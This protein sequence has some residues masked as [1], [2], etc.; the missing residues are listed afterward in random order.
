MQ[1]II[2]KRGHNGL[3]RIYPHHVEIDRRG[4]LAAW[5]NSLHGVTSIHFKDIVSMNHKNRGLVIGWIYFNIQ[6]NIRTPIF[7]NHAIDPHLISY[8]RDDASWTE[9]YEYLQELVYDYKSRIHRVEQK[10]PL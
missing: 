3:L 1:P 8:L 10:A 6:G 4:S 5:L 9:L 2:E 7:Y